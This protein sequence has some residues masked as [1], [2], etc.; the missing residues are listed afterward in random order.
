MTV[1]VDADA[2]LLVGECHVE[3]AETLA[4]LL[5]DGTERAIDVSACEKMHAAVLQALLAFR[6]EVRG[7]PR[8]GFLQEWIVP[9]LAEQHRFRMPSDKT[10][11]R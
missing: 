4:G 9:L 2:I 10:G 6:P 5:S 7:A 8:G 1:K 3:D 11:S